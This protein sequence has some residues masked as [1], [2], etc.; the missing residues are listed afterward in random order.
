MAIISPSKLK[1]PFQLLL[2]HMLYFAPNSI[3]AYWGVS[4]ISSSNIYWSVSI[5]DVYQIEVA[6]S[7]ILAP[8]FT[9]GQ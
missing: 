8:S 7:I 5:M 3:S 6:A 2:V 4:I 1:C 9:N